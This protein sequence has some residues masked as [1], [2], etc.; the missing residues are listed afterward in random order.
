METLKLNTRLKTAEPTVALDPELPP[1]RYQVTLVVSGERGE[2]L[3]AELSLTVLGSVPRGLQ[4]PRGRSAK[5]RG[6]KAR[7]GK[8]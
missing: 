5:P 3:P 7:S 2:S 1:G 8:S 6:G 4:P